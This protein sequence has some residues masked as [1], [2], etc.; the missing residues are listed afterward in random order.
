MREVRIEDLREPQRD[1][2]EQAFFEFA[3]S[4][5]IDL[6]PDRLT[7]QAR[8]DTGLSDFGD[9][10]LVDRLTAQVDAVEADR[11]LSGLG[12]YIVRQRLL[13]LLTA[14]LR[15]EVEFCERLLP[16][17]LDADAIRSLVGERLATL[18][19]TDPKQVGRLVGDIMKSHK[20]RVDAATVKRVAEELLARPGQV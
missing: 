19:I 18:Q 3:C 11:G 6:D 12:R 20:G 13:G 7:A 9:I 14:R 5:E 2:D 10:T 4:M 1:A 17:G 16:K 8:V 15:F